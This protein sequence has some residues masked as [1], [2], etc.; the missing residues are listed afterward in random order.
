M[1]PTAVRRLRL[2]AII[3]GACLLLIA[4]AATWIASLVRASRPQLNGEAALPGASATMTVERDEIG[5]A[6]V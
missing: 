1:S 6:H 4:G 2:A 3:A 5:R